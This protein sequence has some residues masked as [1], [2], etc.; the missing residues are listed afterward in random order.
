MHNAVSPAVE[1][2]IGRLRGRLCGAAVEEYLGIPF[3]APPI[4]A[5]RFQPPEPPTGWHG[6]RDATRC[7]PA[8]LQP[9]S[10]RARLLQGDPGPTDEDCLTL[11][12]WT[13]TERA[14]PLPVLVWVHGGAFTNGAGSIPVVC[15][16]RLAEIASC[17]VVT[18]NYRLGALGFAHHD[19]IT[20]DSPNRGLLDVVAALEWVRDHIAAFGGDTARVTLGGESAGSMCV[21]LLSL[22]PELRC[23]FRQVI[24]HSGIPT[25]QSPEAARRA[26]EALAQRVDTTVSGLRTVPAPIL[27]E[28]TREITR[29][30]FW[31]VAIGPFSDPLSILT[32]HA[33]SRPTLIST[34]ADEGSFF[35]IDDEWPEGITDE[36]IL[37]AL[38]TTLGAQV[39][40][41]VASDAG[42]GRLHES[43]I[44][45]ITNQ[46][47][48]KPADQW[49]TSLTAGA[50]AVFRAEFV[51][52]VQSWGGVLGATHT[53][54][55]PL[56][57]DT[58]DSPELAKLYAD[59]DQTERLAATLQQR[60][61]RF[62]HTG[63]P[64]RSDDPWPSWT[65]DN[66]FTQRLS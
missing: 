15:G 12:V 50:S 47:Y 32:Q 10:A 37:A 24:L 65:R 52:P 6:I 20:A 18:L 1:L 16:A 9:G 3:C 48:T 42:S 33:P 43:T 56:L 14:A 19:D 35:L 7:G 53:I 63:S 5:R 66:P 51:H 44:Q 46:L 17:V 8:S 36:K 64:A 13:P 29:H 11:N 28:G 49:A 31:P 38:V 30:R 40:H 2:S 34:T 21:A 62:L 39:A 60:W 57:F 22:Q 4:G 45:A 54:D 25:L 55:I 23:L 27:V 58:H 59:D 26:V 61:A 41:E